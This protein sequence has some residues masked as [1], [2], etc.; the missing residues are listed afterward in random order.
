MGH[1]EIIRQ[2]LEMRDK[3][4]DGESTGE[5]FSDY[6]SQYLLVHGVEVDGRG[7]MVPVL[8]G[9][10]AQDFQEGGPHVFVSERV[11]DGVDEGIALGQHQ[12]VLLIAQHLTLVT[13]QA[14]QEQDHQTRRPAEHETACQVQKEGRGSPDA[15]GVHKKGGRLKKGGVAKRRNRDLKN[16]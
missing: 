3:W 14:V 9:A 8:P 2:A 6:L 5:F 11:D 13:A 4:S 12:A 7:G 1:F 16:V 15:L 10:A